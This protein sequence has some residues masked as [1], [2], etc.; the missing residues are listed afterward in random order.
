MTAI[1]TTPTAAELDAIIDRLRDRL[2]KSRTTGGRYNA[3][4]QLE[5]ALRLKGKMLKAKMHGEEEVK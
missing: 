1:A 2:A 5:A 3:H 4:S